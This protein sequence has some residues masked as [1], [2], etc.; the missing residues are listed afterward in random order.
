[1]MDH[2]MLKIDLSKRSY[3]VEEIPKDVIRKYIGGRGLGS[4]LLY[5]FVP[6][7][8]D[9]L[10]EENHVIFTA[11]PVN[12]T[13]LFYSPKANINTKSPLTGIYL[14]AISSGILSLEMRKAGLWAIDIKG[15]SDSPT[16]LAI[17]DREV[18]FKDAASL[19]GLE[20]AVAQEG[21]LKDLNAKK[22]AT[23]GIG[24]AGE[25][26]VPS[27]AVFCEGG[28]YR[29]FGRGG[30]GAVMGSKK[31]KGLVMSGTG[32][33]EIADK[34]NPAPRY[35]IGVESIA[36]YILSRLLPARWMDNVMGTKKK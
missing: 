20:T 12:G 10:G 34:E 5:K 9:P 36:L 16:Y 35:R 4:Y 24:P 25:Q 15:M 33:V 26:M 23:V 14:F 32:D 3:D 22:S 29:C 1:M 6:A 19:W 11:G 28:L 18:T 17:N 8:T 2:L 21:M 27:A 30:A 13:S 31:L 7:G